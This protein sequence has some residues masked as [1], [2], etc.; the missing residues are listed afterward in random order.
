MQTNLSLTYNS[1]TV[2]VRPI[3]ETT[4]QSA[5]APG[6]NPDHGAAHVERNSPAAG[7]VFH[8]GSQPGR[9]LP[10][11][12]T[13][14]QPGHGNGHLFLDG[15]D[16]GDAAGRQHHP[17]HGLGTSPVVVAGST[18]PIGRG[19]SIGGTAELI[20]DGNGG[21]IWID[22]NGGTRDFEAG[23]GTTFV[24]P[25]N[26]MGSLVKNSNGTFTY[27]NPQQDQ[28]NFNSSGELTSITRSGRAGGELSYN[29]SGKLT[30]VTMPG[31]WTTT[32]NYNSSNELTAVDE[33]GG[34]VID[35]D[36]RLVRRSHV[37]TMPDGSR[38]DTPTTRRVKCSVTRWVRKPPATLTTQRVPS[39]R[40][41][42][43][44]DKR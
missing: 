8:G 27:T 17:E 19:W 25:T 16:P 10:A 5:S 9:Y 4:Y 24:S 41:V 43:D 18:D 40:P 20:P 2:D 42:T 31:G 34:R 38:T 39:R 21:Y 3:I 23:N 1:D 14:R 6:A 11:Q 28:W 26:D 13:G 22:G 32:F 35:D 33:P 36:V 37:A 7:D 29:S 30:G 12:H 44:R 15:H